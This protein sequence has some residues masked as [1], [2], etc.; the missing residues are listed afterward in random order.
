MTVDFQ[1]NLRLL[2][3]HYRSVAEV[4]RQIGVNRSQFNKYL[5]GRSAPSRHTL[6][7]IC[8]FFGV[9]DYELLLPHAEF[10]QVVGLRPAA[11]ADDAMAG[12]PYVTYMDQLFERSRADLLGYEGF[13]F[14]YAYSMT[15]PG[16]VLRSLLRM[17]CENG[18]TSYQRMENM[19]RLRDRTPRVKCKYR[20]LAF[21]LNDRIFLVD[22]DSLTGNEIS[23]TVLY[24][25]Y[26][27]QLTRLAGLKLGVSASP[28]REPLCARVV[29]ESLGRSTDVKSALRKCGL[30]EQN[31]P[32][33][34][35]QIGAMIVN[36]VDDG[37]HHFQ[38]ITEGR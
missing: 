27:S 5:S 14:E 13:Y 10:R 22:F 31:D 24:P 4:C 25:N 6:K 36:G 15:Y 30:L 32:D 21:Y 16:L 29:L 2:S 18:I 1:Q 8:D 3:D 20:G 12:R 9:E 19:A 38:V 17:T 33:L 34:D 28:R 7:K 37:S 11:E 23:Q 35:S 26:Q